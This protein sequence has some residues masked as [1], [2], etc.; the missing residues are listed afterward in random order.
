MPNKYDTGLDKCPANH[1][2][3]T[4]LRFLD[5]AADVFPNRTAVIHGE[6]R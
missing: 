2:P 4:V 3:M 5:R 1:Q 6:R